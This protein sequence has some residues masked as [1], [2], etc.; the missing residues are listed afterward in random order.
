M[1]VETALAASDETLGFRN[2]G[3]AYLAALD[4]AGQNPS[5]NVQETVED[6]SAAVDTENCTC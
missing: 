1:A 5:E 3:V 4:A 6:T 2:Y